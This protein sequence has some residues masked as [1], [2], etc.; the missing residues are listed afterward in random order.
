MW[1][2]MQASQLAHSLT[3]VVEKLNQG[4]ETAYSVGRLYN[5][6]LQQEGSNF[7]VSMQSTHETVLNEMPWPLVLPCVKTAH[8]LQEGQPLP[9]TA[10][11]TSVSRSNRIGLRV[12][13]AV[14]GEDRLS[15][16]NAELSDDPA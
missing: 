5:T 3:H 16:G 4:G 15:S 7:F 11:Q 8:W 13:N 6:W 9:E 14:L 2:G 1:W 10:L 12:P